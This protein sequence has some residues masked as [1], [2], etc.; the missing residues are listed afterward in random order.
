MEVIC[1]LFQP[2]KF[3][4]LPQLPEEIIHTILYVFKCNKF[5]PDTDLSTL[6]LASKQLFRLVTDRQLWIKLITTKYPQMLNGL[7]GRQCRPSRSE[8]VTQNILRGHSKELLHMQ[9][10]QGL[11]INNPVFYFAFQAAQKIQRLFLV[12]SL[13]RHMRTRPIIDEI[14]KSVLISKIHCQM[15]K[16]QISKNKDAVHKGLR[17]RREYNQIEQSITKSEIY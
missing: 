8:L 16:L 4:S 2:P 12:S 14:R 10:E 17:R 13:E 11:Y 9:I 6:K 7:L 5:V 3:M 1:G 15:Q